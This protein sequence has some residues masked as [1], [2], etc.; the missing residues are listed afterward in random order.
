TTEASLGDGT[1]ALPAFLAAG[2]RFGIGTDSHV[3]TAPRD[4]L[5]QL[6][7]SQR[8][9]DHARAVATGQQTPHPGRTLYEAALAGGAQASGRALG[10]IAPGMR[11]DFVELD[12]LHPTLVGRAEDALLDA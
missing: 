2:G 1:F 5:R 11:A 3:G 6:E 4:E 10:A 7:T 9:R 12:P 8:L